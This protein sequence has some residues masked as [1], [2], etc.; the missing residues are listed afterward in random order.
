MT[1]ESLIEL[2]KIDCNCNNCKYMIRNIDKF[3]KSIE[4]HRKLQLDNFNNNKNKLIV[5]SNFYK[6]RFN[7]LEL[8]DKL[9]TQADKLVFQFN[10]NEITIQYGKCDKLKKDVSFIPNTCQLKTQKCFEHRSC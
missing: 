6:N 7:D 10:K 8:W 1:S 5:K 2:Q 9:L 4:F 3:N